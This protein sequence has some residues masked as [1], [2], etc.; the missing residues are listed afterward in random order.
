M[1]FKKVNFEPTEVGL[2]IKKVRTENGMSQKEFAN[3]IGT[4]QSTVCNW[5]R[6]RVRHISPYYFGPLKDFFGLDI[7]RIICDGKGK[8]L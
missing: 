3:V 2:A 1:K 4:T 5:E 6:F 7:E 8:E